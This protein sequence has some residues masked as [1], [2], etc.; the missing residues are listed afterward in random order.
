MNDFRLTRDFEAYG[1]HAFTLG[2][3]GSFANY[4]SFWNFNNILQEVDG[5]PRGLEVYAVDDDG[6]DGAEIV[7]AVTQNSFTRYG[8][9][10]RNYDADVRILALYLVD[11]WQVTDALRVDGGIR[12]ENLRINGAAESLETFDL[13]D[14]NPLISTGE[15]A[16]LADD[17]VTF[18]SGRFDPF[19]RTYDNISWT[20]GANYTFN[21]YVAVYGR[22][23]DAFRTPDPNDLAANPGAAADIPVNDIFQA[24]AGVKVD[25]EYARAF[26]TGFYSEFTDALFSDPVLDESGNTIEA[27][28][29]LESETLGVEAELDV[30]PFAG[31]RV[32]LKGTVQSPEIVGFD[33]IGAPNLGAGTGAEFDGNEIQRIANEFFVIQPSYEVIGDTWDGLAYLQI[34]TVGDRFANNTN[35][36]LLPS[37]T[38]LSAG[39]LVNYK[40][41]EFTLVGDNLTNEIGVTEGNPRS[42]F[43]Q[44]GDIQTATFARPIL[45]RNFRV[46][47]GYR[48]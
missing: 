17:A 26:V 15:L 12:F 47:V 19:E 48:F 44:A 10:Y 42:D 24:E 28:T 2:A 18:G 8:D 33:F 13:S 11:E 41:L 46:K 45:G 3:Y 43:V 1:E 21:D 29:L 20:L 22:I 39:L 31:F 4:Q 9:F 5:S 27:Q 14:E 6:I 37:Y 34:F 40:G 35:T 16:T 23:N 30:G 7:G 25:T 36:V 38:T 32:N